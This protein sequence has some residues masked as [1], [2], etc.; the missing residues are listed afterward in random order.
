MKIFSGLQGRITLVF[1]PIVF[2]VAVVIG[3]FQLRQGFQEGEQQAR[4]TLQNGLI[5]QKIRIE[6]FLRSI[7][8]DLAFLNSV[9]PI[10]GIIRA[11]ANNGVDPRDGSSLAV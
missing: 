1:I 8:T 2:V 3:V 9:P 6:T 7:E 11:R 5:S 10:Q 4:T